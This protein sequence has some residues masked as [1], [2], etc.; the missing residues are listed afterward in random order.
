M[1]KRIE[2]HFHVT[3]GDVV[4]WLQRLDPDT[5]FG[6]IDGH[7]GVEFSLKLDTVRVDPLNTLHWQERDTSQRYVDQVH[8]RM[9]D[10]AVLR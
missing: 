10:V 9:I 4:K 7:E 6:L 2:G 3:V 1:S 5:P 8:N